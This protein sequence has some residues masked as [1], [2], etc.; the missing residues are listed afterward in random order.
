[1]K[2][3]RMLSWMYVLPVVALSVS[4]AASEPSDVYEQ[5]SHLDKSNLGGTP[6]V[7]FDTVDENLQPVSMADLT[8]GK[9]LVM[10]VSS[11]S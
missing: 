11:A 7:L 5:F 6:A 2:T 1:M 8:D 9:P 10:V 4:A 3:M